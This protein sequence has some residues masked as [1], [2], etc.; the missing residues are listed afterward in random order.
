MKGMLSKSTLTN[1]EF[2]VPPLDLQSNF[3]M[4]FRNY[5]EQ[6]NLMQKSLIEMDNNFNSIMQ[7]AFRGELF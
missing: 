3:A 7:H 6:R 4:V 2:I 5:L 1:L